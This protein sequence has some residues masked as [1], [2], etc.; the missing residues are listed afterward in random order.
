M[1]II[2]IA[3]LLILFAFVIMGLY[4]GFTVSILSTISYI[5][6]WVLAW[7]FYPVLAGILKSGGVYTAILNLSDGAQKLSSIDLSKTPIANLDTS[8]ITQIVSNA[9]LPAPFNSALASNIQSAAL[10]SQNMTTVGDYFNST[11]AMVLTNILCFI[12]IFIVSQN[13]A[14]AS[15]ILLSTTS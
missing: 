3:I 15:S 14:K 7:L 10:S 12:V 11:V 5:L 6:S 4:Q 13:P 9:K 2:D 8:Q 1:N